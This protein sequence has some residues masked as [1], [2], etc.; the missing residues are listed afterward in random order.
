MYGW[1]SSLFTQNYHNTINLSCVSMCSVTSVVS[2]SVALWTITHKTL[3]STGLSRQEY[4]S[5]LPCPPPWD[6][7]TQGSN[8]SLLPLLHCRWILY[9]WATG[10]ACS[11]VILQSKIKSLKF[12][13]K[14]CSSSTYSHG[15]PLHF[16]FFLLR[17]HLIGNV[18]LDYT[19]KGTW[20]YIYTCAHRHQ[21]LIVPLP[22]FSLPSENISQSH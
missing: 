15:S 2:D 12:N 16:F 3:L 9:R 11:L 7:L 14:K 18:Y 21:L 22:C 17:C 20:L 8:L 13:N 4:W 1:V 10:E 6:L 19:I 5:G